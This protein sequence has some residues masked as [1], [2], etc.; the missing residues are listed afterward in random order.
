MFVRYFS[1]LPV[2]YEAASRAL[3]AAPENWLPGVD[4]DGPR[5]TSELRA[6]LGGIEIAK[7]MEVEIGV[8]KHQESKTVIPIWWHA[9]GPKGLFPLLE[10]YL[11]VAP[12]PDGTTMLVLLVDYAPPLG[13]LGEKADELFLHRFAEATLDDFRRRVGAAIQTAAPGEAP[14]AD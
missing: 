11:E 2:S 3:L 12:T 1:D 6:R 10:G 4:R 7:H 8:P 5:L 9:T 13:A 14:R